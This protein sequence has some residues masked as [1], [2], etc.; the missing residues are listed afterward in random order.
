MSE[1][2]LVSVTLRSCSTSRGREE[3]VSLWSLK[4]IYIF[5]N[6]GYI[7]HH[8]NHWDWESKV[9]NLLDYKRKTTTMTNFL[10]FSLWEKNGCDFG[11][12]YGKEII[13][14]KYVPSS[15]SCREHASMVWNMGF[16]MR[17]NR[18]HLRLVCVLLSLI[19]KYLPCRFIVKYQI[20]RI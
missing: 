3:I 13:L 17:E 7:Q 10:K 4:C 18:S 16:L 14:S 1:L 2:I 19:R 12:L 20:E 11:F 8:W 9:T 15:W 5:W 6:L